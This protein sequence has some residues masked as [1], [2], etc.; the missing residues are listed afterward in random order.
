M[1]KRYHNVHI[2]LNEQTLSDHIVTTWLASFVVSATFESF[3]FFFVHIDCSPVKNAIHPY[4]LLCLMS[5][6][7]KSHNFFKWMVSVWPLNLASIKMLKTAQLNER[8][9][10]GIVPSVCSSIQSMF[11]TL[12]VSRIKY[13]FKF[14]FRS[15][16]RTV[17]N[18]AKSRN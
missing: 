8:I 4:N 3:L 7:S 6:N 11:L 1:P 18:K 16:T 14:H 10:N 9:K 2:H 12:D 17:A 13:I 5:I 15:F